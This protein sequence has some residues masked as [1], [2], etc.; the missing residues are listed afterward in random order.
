MKIA[1]LITGLGLGGAER[2]LKALVTERQQESSLEHIVIS[3]QDE[4]VIGKQLS[5]E[6]GVRLYCLNLHKSIAG[7][8]QLYKILRREKP[9]VLQTWLYHAD[10]MGLLIGKLARVPHIVWNIRCS[11]MELSQYSRLTAFVV[12]ILKALSRFPDA[13]VTNSQS[14]QK[15]HTTLGY[16]PRRWVQIPNGIDADLFQ[17][18]IPSGQDLRRTFDIPEDAIV[19]GLLGRV[20]PMKDYPTFLRAM[21]RL[22]LV[23]ENLY[24]M[25]AG[26][27][28][29]DASW[30]IV[31]PRFRRLGVWENASAF[32]NALD[33][34]VLSSAFGEGFPN[35]V[36]EAMACEVPTIV[37]DVGD[38]GVLI[39]TPTQIVPP[40]DV[41]KLILAL[42]GLLALSSGE[43]KVIGQQSRSR[44]LSSYSLPIMRQRYASFYKDLVRER[45]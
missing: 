10:L 35:V 12:K 15:F 30:A 24:C 23:H 27:G 36:G 8:W 19:V 37:T 45:L 25:V 22:S 6:K 29:E 39:Q 2:Q 40:Q 21:E 5:G 4:G 44:V 20:D 11:N 17:P 41:D 14:G 42:K 26:K 43:R 3:L 18:N 28:T 38:A 1:H 13:V 7:V 33:I 32:L 9:D 31:P 34:L 16:A